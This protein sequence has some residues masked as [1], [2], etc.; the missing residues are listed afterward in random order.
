MGSL[1]TVFTILSSLVS[2][3]AILCMIR[4][5]LTWIP[6]AGSSKFGRF[7]VSVCDPYLN[8]FRNI[9]WMHIGNFDFGPAVAL[10]ILGAVSAIL[11]SFSV[12]VFSLSYL[13]QT[14]VGLVWN[15]IDSIL[16][17]IV[18][19]LA[20]RLIIIFVTK[21]SYSPNPIL[22]AIDNSLGLL[23]DRVS[24]TFVGN[25]RVPYKTQL[26]TTI[27]VFVVI[28]IVGSLLIGALCNLIGLIRI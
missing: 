26:I 16:I 12:G 10:C 13:L 7:L 27:I 4:I 19:V 22:N 2:A 6:Q 15:I 21:N 1:R 3:Y 14:I 11:G 23:A 20:V 25:K 8:L 28:M 24:R 5:I 17:F 18:V 9:K